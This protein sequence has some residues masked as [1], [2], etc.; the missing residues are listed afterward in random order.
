[1]EQKLSYPPDWQ[2]LRRNANVRIDALQA[3]WE[4]APG[5]LRDSLRQNWCMPALVLLAEFCASVDIED[6]DEIE[7]E[8]DE[9]N[10][11]LHDDPTCDDGKEADL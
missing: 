5:R 10:Q 7:D 9:D 8:Q 6:Q 11:L 2:K 1:M 3:V 4:I